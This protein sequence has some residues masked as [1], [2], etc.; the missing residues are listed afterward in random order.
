MQCSAT[1][2]GE[3]T[4]AVRQCMVY[5][6]EEV[7]FTLRKWALDLYISGLDI[8]CL[9]LTGFDNEPLKQT[10]S[11]SVIPHKM[12]VYTKQHRE[13]CHVFM[14]QGVIFVSLLYVFSYV[15]L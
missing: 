4:A 5:E 6:R 8:V 15:T 9:L 13:E 3:S 11:F 14:L 2:G 12:V 10:H 7:G 1:R